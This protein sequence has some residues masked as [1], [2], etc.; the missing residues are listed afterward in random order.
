[1]SNTNPTRQVLW[2]K[3]L[4]QSLQ[5][6]MAS[7]LDCHAYHFSGNLR[8]EVPGHLQNFPNI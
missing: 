6:L 8:M 4:N 2:R 1:M 7:L 5:K 3:A